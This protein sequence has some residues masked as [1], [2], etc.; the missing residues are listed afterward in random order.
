MVGLVLTGKRRRKR[1][2]SAAWMKLHNHQRAGSL[3]G[4]VKFLL[5]DIEAL[6]NVNY[7]NAE[8]YPKGEGFGARLDTIVANLKAAQDEL[9]AISKEA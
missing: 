1:M 7:G 2:A 9:V 5:M 8:S 4:S 3:A 6:R